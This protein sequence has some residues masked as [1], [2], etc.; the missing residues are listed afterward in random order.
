MKAS[1]PFARLALV[2]VYLAALLGAPQQA[3]AQPAPVVSSALSAV[4]AAVPGEVTFMRDLFG[5]GQI[6]TGDKW[7]IGGGY[8]YWAQ[9]QAFVPRRVNQSVEPQANAGR[10]G[11]LRRWPIH[12]GAIATLSNEG[13][14]ESETSSWAADESGLYYGDS[15]NIL[16]RSTSSPFTVETIA[17][18]AMPNSRII[19]NNGT[20][21]WR[22][23]IFWLANNTLYS[24]NKFTLRQLA[25]PEPLG[26]NAHSL[27]FANDSNFYW[28]ADGVL[29]RAAKACL[30]FG[31]G[32]CSKEVVAGENGDNVTDAKL[33]SRISSSSTFPLWTSGTSIR[34]IGCSFGRTGYNCAP[35]NSYTSA[36]NNNVGNLATDGEF[37]FWVENRADVCSGGIFG[38]DYGDNG[39][40]MKWSLSQLDSIINP[41]QFDTPQQIACKQCYANYTINGSPSAVAVADGWVYFNTSNGLS[42][43]RA[44]APPISWDLAFKGWEIT[45]GIQNLNNDVPLVAN[46]PT[47]VRVYGNKSSGPNALSVEGILR[48]TTINGAV[49]GSL[50]SLNSGQNFTANNAMP[51]RAAT[52]GGWLFQLPESWTNAGVTKLSFQIDPRGAWN[53]PNPGNN[54]APLQAFTFT[55][56]AP[57]C[58]V[59][60]P[61]R[62]IAPR[63][64]TNAPNFWQ[65][66][67]RFKTLWPVS[68]VWV[69]QQDED[70]AEL[71]IKWGGPFDLIPYPGYGPYEL[72]EGGSLF[73]GIISDKDKV[74]ISLIERDVFSD[75]PDT[76]DDANGR[77]HYVGMVHPDAPT[78]TSSG[79]ANYVRAASWVKF[80]PHDARGEASKFTLPGAGGTMAQELSHNYNGIFGDRW[81]HV[82]C[83]GPDG[84]NPN[85]PYDPCKLDNRA[86]TDPATYFGFDPLTSTPIAPDMASDYM[87][88][89]DNN[90]V[91]DYSWRGMFGEVKT[92]VRAAQQM[93]RT[94]GA[95]S[96]VNLRAAEDAVFVTGVITAST[97]LADLNN[98]WRMPKT[99]MTANVLRKWQDFAVTTQRVQRTT[100]QNEAQYQLR[101]LDAT[102]ATLGEYFVTATS[103]THGI[104][105]DTLS[106]AASFPAPAGQV[107]RLELRDGDKLLGSLNA[108]GA[109]P[110]VNIISPAGGEAVDDALTL[111][112]R[113]S[114]ADPTDRLLFSVQYSPDNGQH[115][116]A[117]LTNFPNRSGSDTVTLSLAGLNGIPASTTGGL[118]RVIASDGYNTTIAVSQPFTVANRAPTPHIDAP[119]SAPLPAGQTIILSGSAS[120]VEDG[121]LSGAAL[122][123]A[124]DGA[125]IGNGQSQIIE[126]LAPGIHTL[127]LTARDAAGKAATATQTITVAPLAIPK[128]AA[129]MFDGD[130]NDNAYT[131]AARVSL[132]PYAD[133]TQAFVALARTDDAL[134]ACFSGMKRTAAGSPGTLA[135]V[136]INTDYGRRSVPGVGDRVFYTD[137]AGV[138]SRFDGDG[139]GYVAGSGGA[140]AQISANSTIWNVEMRIDVGSVGGMNHVVGLGVE[141]ALVS[142]SSDR[143]AWPQGDGASNPSSW[144]AASLGDVPQISNVT[145]ASVPVGAGG[146]VVTIDGSSFVAGAT[147]KFNS[148][149]LATTVVSGTQVQATIPATNLAAAGMFNLTVVN[150]GLEAAPSN[151]LPFSVANPLP[152]ISQVALAGKTL[153]VS[154]SNFAAGATIQF[155]GSNYPATGNTMR[156]SITLSAADVIGNANASITVFN[157]GPGGGVSNVV[158]LGAGSGFNT[159]YLPLAFGR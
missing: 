156:L 143:Y 154:G 44:D 45:Q 49:L 35:G 5:A 135:V 51:N 142:S 72:D 98:A 36:L 55:R 62:T 94:P 102:N 153:T 26:A 21:I 88:Y 107:A 2:F 4:L 14:C 11:Y 80:P 83:N 152:Q 28:F 114:D 115:W 74:I 24:A 109:L 73:N 70:I 137:E 81:K 123:W 66:I 42:R 12:G 140:G 20:T 40:L 69:F 41:G 100:T 87:S 101:L 97:Q 18:S 119:G 90:W 126:G 144:G 75:D 17:A 31:G 57:V 128:T 127:T 29:Y 99:E 116:R 151:G 92:R 91:S 122:G 46:K 34:G 108:G 10:K 15:T 82:N 118:I 78:G 68:D 9:C 131:N 7:L 54:T 120:D 121:G 30:A 125:E 61:V 133:G 138:V 106:F 110:T 86:Y 48:G 139:T 67:E 1:I 59:F 112:W 76:C 32:A 96:V 8:L 56:K 129:P 64:S 148:A 50:R 149:A 19:L 134:Y 124:L 37:L 60:V 111:S 141:Q 103:G 38:C 6:A 71:E 65:M 145:P 58:A 117:L 147:V 159:L 157:P 132:A 43:I 52:D 77:T 27:A 84:V 79:F 53:D 16:R 47:Y 113:A 136:R 155:N 3:A 85:Y 63:A 130:C 13:F 89:G 146:M 93:A 23:Y 105:A 25:A 104:V 95:L 150:P 158:T 22:D 33:S 39:R